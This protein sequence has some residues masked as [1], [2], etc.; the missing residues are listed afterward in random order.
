MTGAVTTG[1]VTA[2]PVTAGAVTAGAVT[3][4][5]GST[6]TALPEAPKKG[7]RLS[8]LLRLLMILCLGL[9]GGTLI[10]LSPDIAVP[11]TILL[12]PGLITLL[13]DRTPGQRLARA[14]LLFQAAA[15]LG[16]L[17]QAWYSC[18]GLHECLD[19]LLPP[20]VVI[21]VWLAAAF[22]WAMTQMLPIGLKLLEDHRLRR[23][24]VELEKRRKELADE[25]GLA[26]RPKT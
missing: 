3:A 14:M 2:G 20:N 6:V 9:S 23:R 10:A 26:A 1:G 21:K 12:L 8:R 18:S 13:M 15:A 22:A 11:M 19:Y 25:W 4:G 7:T 5:F 17:R 16:P 24:R